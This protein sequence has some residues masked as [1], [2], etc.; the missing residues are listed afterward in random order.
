MRGII[1]TI[2]GSTL[3]DCEGLSSSETRTALSRMTMTRKL[4]SPFLTGIMTGFPTL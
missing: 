3:M 1:P 2:V 4:S